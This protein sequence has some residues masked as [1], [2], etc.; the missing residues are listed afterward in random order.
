[1][2]SFRTRLED[3]LNT[4]S[5]IGHH[6]EYPSDELLSAIDRIGYLYEEWVVE[7]QKISGKDLELLG[8]HHPIHPLIDFCD[9][10]YA[11]VLRASGADTYHLWLGRKGY[12]FTAKTARPVADGVPY[13][14][15][16]GA[17]YPRF[18]AYM[19]NDDK[20]D[21]WDT[22]RKDD[23]TIFFDDPADVLLVYFMRKVQPTRDA[24]LSAGIGRLL[25]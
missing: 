2:I 21:Y 23:V 12:I 1:M 20:D 3:A 9:E 8:L 13:T 5:F 10:R 15:A 25:R 22:R 7:H 14:P 24:W 18:N 11:N 6:E 16:E 4:I 19:A 17:L